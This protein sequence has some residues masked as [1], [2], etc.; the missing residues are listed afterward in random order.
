MNHDRLL[1]LAVVKSAKFVSGIYGSHLAV[2]FLFQPLPFLLQKRTLIL[3][4]E[5]AGLFSGLQKPPLLA[6][7]C[8]WKNPK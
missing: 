2:V 8:C 3:Y 7:R 4:H 6:T 1:N 5:V